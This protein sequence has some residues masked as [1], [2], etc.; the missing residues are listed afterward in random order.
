VSSRFSGESR[1]TIETFERTSHRRRRG[2]ATVISL[3]AQVAEIVAALNA[4]GGEAHRTLV[5]QQIART[6]AGRPVAVTPRLEQDIIAVF[7]AHC[8][9]PP[10]VTPRLTG[11]FGAGSH[12]WALA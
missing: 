6:R 7:E 5:L 11:R 8:R 10:D 4:L 1:V 2:R 9:L 3:D 12:R